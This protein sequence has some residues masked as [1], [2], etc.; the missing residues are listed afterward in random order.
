MNVDSNGTEMVS[1]EE[2]EEGSGW[3]LVE[4]RPVSEGVS[5]LSKRFEVAEY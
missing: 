5:L 2:P 3:R 4:L 1:I